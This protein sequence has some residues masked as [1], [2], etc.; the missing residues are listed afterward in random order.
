MTDYLEEIKNAQIIR[1]YRPVKKSFDYYTYNYE[2]KL[3][4]KEGPFT[5]YDTHYS[6]RSIIP[7]DCPNVVFEAF[8]FVTDNNC[9]CPSFR[10]FGGDCKHMLHKRFIQQSEKYLKNQEISSDAIEIIKKML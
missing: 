10:Y 2:K 6:Y 1:R 4:P 9:T 5:R 8:Y 3:L 7:L